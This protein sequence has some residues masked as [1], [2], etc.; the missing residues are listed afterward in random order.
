MKLGSKRILRPESI[1][2]E[3]REM[4][5]GG[6]SYGEITSKLKI[7][8]STLHT[9]LYPIK[10]PY[11]E[12][13]FER[14]QHLNNI[15]PLAIKKLKSL[16]EDRL[17]L[18]SKKVQNEIP[19]YPTGNMFFNKGLLSM[20]YW[21]EGSKGRGNVS[22]ANT[23]PNLALLYITLLRKC[24][25]LDETKF[26]MRLHLHYYHNVTEIRNYWS[27]L[28]EI[29]LSRIGKIYFKKRGNSGKRFRKNF[30]GICFIIYYSEN[31]RYEIL[32]TGKL[33]AKN[34]CS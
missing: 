24:Y 15:R 12:I 17:N 32:E 10:R 9:W 28:L 29:P 22:F 6:A 2:I 30:Y 4:R 5:L 18:I 31:L 20:L 1:K 14:I 33:L 26:R 23:D 25:K 11:D 7:P 21:A 19:N 13:Q 3:A 34:M 27:E 8:K 16:R